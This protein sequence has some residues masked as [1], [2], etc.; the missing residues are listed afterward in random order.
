VNTLTKAI[1]L[2]VKY[3]REL[4][5]VAETEPPPVLS[6][7]ARELKL[8]DADEGFSLVLKSLDWVR[9]LANSF[10]A[11]FAKLLME[12][13]DLL[14]LTFYVF[15]YADAA[16]LQKYQHDAKSQKSAV[17]SRRKRPA[18][19]DVLPDHA[20]AHVATLC[21]GRHWPPSELYA[22]LKRFKRDYP[23]LYLELARK[24]AALHRNAV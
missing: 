17:R 10:S 23:A 9:G 12:S 2:I 5:W 3:R 13:K 8:T 6:T 22:T 16:K 18:K 21:T 20:L 11:P 14:Y 15:E 1:R 24:M 4:L 19:R 7:L